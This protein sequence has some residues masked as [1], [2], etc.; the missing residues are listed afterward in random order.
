[1][2][3]WFWNNERRKGIKKKVHENLENM[4]FRTVDGTTIFNENIYDLISPFVHNHSN[5]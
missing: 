2:K 4:F 3:Y 1:M 5:K